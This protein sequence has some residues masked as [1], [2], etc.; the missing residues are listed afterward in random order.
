MLES[1][2]RKQGWREPQSIFCGRRRGKRLVNS[3]AKGQSCV[4]TLES[5][6]V[7]NRRRRIS[8]SGTKDRGGTRS[9]LFESIDVLTPSDLKYTT[10]HEWIRQEADGSLTIGITAYAQDHLGELVYVELP[11]VGNT[12]TAGNAC[13]V[14]EST[15]AAADVYA[16]IS[17]TII[18]INESL[19]DSPQLVNTAPYT[20][21]W[22]FRVTPDS[23][24][25]AVMAGFMNASAYDSSANAG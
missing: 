19:S 13:A 20:E 17:G 8:I 4:D 6:I 3:Q 5:T 1:L 25:Q 12:L 24:A 15:K 18:A 21:G 23:S 2:R 11:A 9:N 22:L 16:P 7:F 10:S 14:V